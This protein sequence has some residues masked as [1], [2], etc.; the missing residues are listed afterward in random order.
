MGADLVGYMLKGPDKISESVRVGAIKKGRRTLRAMRA[1]RQL[2]DEYEELRHGCD[3]PPVEQILRQDRVERRIRAALLALPGHA[4]VPDVEACERLLESWGWLVDDSD[5]NPHYVAQQV[6]DFCYM[7]NGNGTPRDV[8]KRTF[9][10]PGGGVFQVLFAG[11]QTWGDPPDG[12]GYQMCH[13]IYALDLQ[14]ALG[15]E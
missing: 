3:A 6:N 4:A 15:L 13:I 11:A 5:G 2:F 1:C 10:A 8:C 12:H 9:V 14:D 7:W